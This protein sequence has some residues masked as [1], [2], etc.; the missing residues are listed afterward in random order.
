MSKKW[1]MD[2]TRLTRKLVSEG[3]PPKQLG[4]RERE[5]PIRDS[6]SKQYGLIL[7]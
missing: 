2:E 3:L 4:S 1:S 6:T 7:W 5:N